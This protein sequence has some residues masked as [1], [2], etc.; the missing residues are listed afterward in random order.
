[1]IQN[2]IS[3]LMADAQ[4]AAQCGRRS[5]K[6]YAE[7]VAIFR[8]KG[9]TWAQIWGRMAELG[10]V[11]AADKNGQ[12]SFRSSLSRRK[13]ISLLAGKGKPA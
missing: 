1:M 4:A 8:R 9:W 2:N 13:R 11:D 3:T 10:L 12:I 7:P 5:W 6:E